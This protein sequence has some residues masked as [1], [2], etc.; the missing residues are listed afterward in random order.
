MTGLLAIHHIDT[1]NPVLVPAAANLPPGFNVT[2]SMLD[3]ESNHP[4]GVKITLDMTE[5]GVHAMVG[6][7]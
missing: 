6:A 3:T 5:A 2:Y 4:I 1:R 7:V